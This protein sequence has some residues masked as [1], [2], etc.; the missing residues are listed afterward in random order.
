MARLGT[1]GLKVIESAAP[2]GDTI[3]RTFQGPSASTWRVS[4]ATIGGVPSLLLPPAMLAAQFSLL[5]IQPSD[6]VVLVSGEKLH[7][8]TLA[9]MAFARLGHRDYAVMNGGYAKW[10]QEGRPADTAL[11]A[12]AE[13]KYPVK[14]RRR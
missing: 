10:A 14:K 4:A 3:P 1:P 7:D 11:P 8:A 2:T 12:S 13:S 9:S 5:D 6:T